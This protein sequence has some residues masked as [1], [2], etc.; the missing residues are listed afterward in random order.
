MSSA[1]IRA[2]T[3]SGANWSALTEATFSVGSLGVPLR[4]AEIMYNPPGGSIH[5]YLELEN[6]SS[7]AIDLGGIYWTG[8]I[9]SLPKAQRLRVA[10]GSCLVPTPIPMPG[11]PSIRACPPSVG[12]AAISTTPGSE[13][14][15]STVLETSSPP[16]IISDGGGWP[17]A[18]DGGGR[19][20]EILNANGDPN[21]PANWQ[22]STVAGGTPGAVNSPPPVQSV[23]LSEVMAGNISAVNHGGTFPDWVELRNTTASPV[24]L[25]GWS[26]TDDGEPR[27][28][29]FPSASIPAGGYLVVWCDAATN[30]TPGL[31]AGFSLDQDGET[32]S[33]Y[34]PNTNRIDALTFGLQLTNF[35]VGRIG[36]KWTL[37]SPTTNAANLAVTLASS[38]SLAINEWLANPAPG[39]PDW[40][41]LYN[42]SATAPVSLQGIYLASSN[43]LHQLNSLSFLPPL[44]Y[45]RLFADEGTGLDHL[46]FKLPAEGGRLGLSD[47]A[48]ARPN[49]RVWPPGRRRVTRALSGWRCQ[50]DVLRRHCQSRG[51]QLPFHLHR[52]GD[53]RSPGPKQPVNA[54]GA[55]VDYVELHNPGASAFSLAGMSLSVNSA[56]PGQWSFPPTA[57]LAANSYLLIK[58]DGSAPVSTNVGSFNT[59]RSL[60]G[61][62]GGVHLFSSAGQLVNSVEYGLQVENLP[63]GLS[64]GQWR[65]LSAATP[66]YANAG[67]AALGSSAALRINEW[68]ASLSR[69]ADWFELFNATNLPIDLA[70]VTLSDDPSIAGA[71]KFQPAPLSFIGPGGF[72][73]WVADAD[74]GQGRNHVNFALDEAG[75]SLLV[76]RVNGSAY[77]F[78]QGVGFGA[79]AMGVS[80]GSLPDGTQNVVPFPGSATPGE[81]NYRLLP[82]VVINEALTHTDPPLEDAIELRNPSASAR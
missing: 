74:P 26:L 73:K 50:C 6:I 20:L 80:Q 2:R 60:D 22:A 81:S 19:S 28:F 8:W 56:Q 38:S 65:L 27:K 49:C 58:C 17:A 43:Q 3:L 40:L 21:E 12:L 30:T 66:G 37:N 46:C 78:L 44:G 79:Q 64:G 52:A 10:R 25:A 75:E 11:K 53:Q 41:E 71:G 61:E 48:G 7:A 62:S 76:Y 35:S 34:D 54:G 36:G 15:C 47:A 70:A 51:G 45:V 1:S 14:R 9:S 77:E 63:I 5:E 31:H 57:S 67:P 42:R 39:Y 69:G 29:V 82:N 16:W 59:G 72:V 55:V 13:S 33:L 18:A 68:M 32:I 24:N 4:I 23:Q